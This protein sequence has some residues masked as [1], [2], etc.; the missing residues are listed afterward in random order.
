MHFTASAVPIDTKLPLSMPIMPSVQPQNEDIDM[1]MNMHE[2]TNADTALLLAMMDA[3]IQ[4]STQ[5]NNAGTQTTVTG[6]EDSAF[7]QDEETQALLGQLDM[8][9]AELDL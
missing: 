2:K 3:E 4:Q 7:V 8:F 9:S 6:T 5:P 1:E